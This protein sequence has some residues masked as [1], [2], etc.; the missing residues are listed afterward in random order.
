M[1]RA[2]HIVGVSRTAYGPAT[3][4]CVDWRHDCT[5]HHHDQ[6]PA[7]F[8]RAALSASSLVAAI[9]MMLGRSSDSRH[10]HPRPRSASAPSGEP[11]VRADAPLAD[12]VVTEADGVLPDGVTVFDEQYPGR[13]QPRPRSAARPARSRRRMPRTTASSSS[14]TAAGAPRSTRSSCSARRS[15]STDPKRRRP[16]G[17]PPRTRS[18]HVSGDAV[19]VGSPTPPRGCRARRRGTDCARS[20][21]TSRGT[22]SCAPTRPFR[23]ARRRTPTPRRIRGC[24][25]DRRGHSRHGVSRGHHPGTLR[26]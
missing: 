24:S 17:S 25:S 2:A 21:T 4:R 13:R 18:A 8:V 10:P 7:G 19:D 12:G 6:G 5:R 14:S 23:A 22:S 20:T 1:L 16:D 9:A 15:P 3:P 11:R 26:R